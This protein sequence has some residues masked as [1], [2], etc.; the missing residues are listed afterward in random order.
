MKADIQSFLYNINAQ[1][2]DF[3][4]S[5][6]PVK[7]QE[8]GLDGRCGWDFWVNKDCI[9]VEKGTDSVLQY[10]GGFE[11]V[12]KASRSEVGDYVIY[13]ATDDRVRE[14]I[15]QYFSNEDAELEEED[16]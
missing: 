14:H 10:Y 15:E 9:V 7:P 13:L 4:H 11:Y 8:L 12:N 5:M 3:V 6:D 2:D 16:Y 1:M